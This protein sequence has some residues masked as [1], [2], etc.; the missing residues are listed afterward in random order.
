MSASEALEDIRN[1]TDGR[2]QMD[3]RIEPHRDDPCLNRMIFDLG[4]VASAVRYEKLPSGEI[5]ELYLTNIGFRGYGM[6]LRDERTL[7]PSTKY[8]SG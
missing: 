2:T 1:S 6:I 7:S 5:I 8:F 4:V 3:Y